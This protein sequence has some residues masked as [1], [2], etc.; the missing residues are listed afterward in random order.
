MENRYFLRIDGKEFYP[1]CDWCYKIL[2]TDIPMTE[3]EHNRYCDGQFRLKD[4][5]TGESVFDYIEE[6]V[7]Q[8]EAIEPGIDNF[9]LETDFRLS[10]LE[11]GV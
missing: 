9:M 11:L 8:S 10:K 5:P 4:N 2:S 7:P 3:E 6:Y 1:V